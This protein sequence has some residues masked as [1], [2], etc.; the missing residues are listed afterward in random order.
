MLSK[1]PWA[2]TDVHRER[3]RGFSTLD[4]RF[5]N[6]SGTFRLLATHLLCPC[7]PRGYRGQQRQIDDIIRIVGEGPEPVLMIG[8][9]N[10]TPWSRP[11]AR[12][13]E[14][15]GLRGAPGL[16]ATWPSLLRPVGIPID[17]VLGNGGI[18]VVEA[19]A[20]PDVGSDH[21]PLIAVVRLPR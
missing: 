16:V 11:W 8:D 1:R 15:T 17:H 19:W 4:A 9:L 14:A 5:E 3:L 7:S 21:R 20:G 18:Q 12:L 10:A 2:K 13:V 6:D